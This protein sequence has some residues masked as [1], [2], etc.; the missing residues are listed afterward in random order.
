ML[1]INLHVR[2]KYNMYIDIFNVDTNEIHC[3]HSNRSVNLKAVK[4][5]SFCPPEQVDLSG[6]YG[7]RTRLCLLY[8]SDAADDC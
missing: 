6:G 5:T 4:S 3:I 8:T 7:S 1:T 2:V